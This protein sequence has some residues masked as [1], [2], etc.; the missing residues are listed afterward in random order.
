MD[1][2]WCW[3]WFHSSNRRGGTDANALQ[4]RDAQKTMKKPIFSKWAILAGWLWVPLLSAQ[5]I[6]IPWHAIGPA[7]RGGGGGLSISGSIGQWDAARVSGDGLSLSGGFWVFTGAADVSGPPQNYLV[8]LGTLGGAFENQS[9]ALGINNSGVIVGYSYFAPGYSRA[10]YWADAGSPAVNMGVPAGFDQSVAWKINDFGAFVGWSTSRSNGITHAT[11]W[12]GAQDLGTFGSFPPG[13][14]LNSAALGINA[15]GQVAGYAEGYLAD[16][17][18]PFFSSG[19]YWA[20]GASSP[21]T[22]GLRGSVAYAIN[23]SGEIVGYSSRGFAAVLGSHGYESELVLPPDDAYG[24]IA[25]GI[26]ASGQIIGYYESS[27]DFR[28]HGLF[29]PDAFSPPVVLA[30]LSGSVTIPRSI[31]AAGQ[32]VGYSGGNTIG[33]LQLPS[34]LSGPHAVL[35]LN[36][37][38]P[39]IDLNSVVPAGTGLE[40]TVAHGINDSGEIVGTSMMGYLTRGFALTLNPLAPLSNSVPASATTVAASGHSLFLRSDG[41]LWAMGDN[42]A[43][44]L[45]DST[46]I[47]HYM[48][49]P[50]VAGGVIAVAA[51]LAHSLFLKSDG[52]LWAMGD[53]QY[54]QL[55]DGTSDN[56]ASPVRIVAGGVTAIAAGTYHSLFVKSDG[57]L[58][59]MGWNGSGQLGDGTTTGADSPEQIVPAGVTAIAG[60]YT[61]SLFLKSDGSLWAMGSNAHGELGDGTTADSTIPKQIMSDG[62]ARIAAGYSY[63]FFAKTNGS[64]WAV[65]NNSDGQLG[66][67]TMSNAQSPE[68]IVAGGVTAIATGG[69]WDFHSLFLKSDGSLWAFGDNGYGELGDGTTNVSLIPEQIVCAGVTAIACGLVHSLFVRSDGSLWAMGA[70]YTGQL[71]DGGNSGMQLTP[72]RIVAGAAGVL[73][74]GLLITS[75]A[76]VG[77]DFQ[78]S[79]TSEYCLTYSVLGTTDLLSGAWTVLQ[80]GIPGN[81]ATV[82]VTIPNTFNQP[83]QFFRIKQE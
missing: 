36:A 7:G 78:L 26:N 80:T 58:W 54:G 32:I 45:G 46:S 53:N 67:G 68:Q 59:A 43:G 6:T 44:Q 71:G 66:D 75:A 64:L 12:A 11:S 50:I 25:T 10:V 49:E 2:G 29:W 79:F 74:P 42:Y 56:R 69:T 15:A 13:A 48:P 65:G 23:D 41:S 62:V 9:E 21:S 70:D 77:N 40:L 81:G 55:G 63:S 76:R 35:W 18:I 8:N 52:S 1:A 38:S 34:G 51:G 57:S 28:Y 24:S 83:Q 47:A 20:P 22:L 61:H 73:P 19:A 4:R 14:Q 33:L 3:C 31:N 72:E 16:S 27:V 82:Q 37:T 60:G 30:D 5:T 39:P 17:S